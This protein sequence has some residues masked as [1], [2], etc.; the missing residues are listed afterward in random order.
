MTQQFVANDKIMQSKEFQKVSNFLS[1]KPFKGFSKEHLFIKR[2]IKKAWGQD[3]AALSNMAEAVENLWRRNLIDQQNAASQIQTITRMAMHKTVRPYKTPLEQTDN[4]GHYGYF[5]EHLNLILNCHQ[6]INGDGH[7]PLNERITLHLKTETIK[8]KNLHAR[9]LP[10]VRMRWSADQALIINS[11]RGFDRNN[12]TTHHNDLADAWISKM[13]RDYCHSTGLFQTEVMNCK[14][15]SKEPRGC[16][17]AY[18]IYYMHNFAPEVAESQWNLFKKHMK[19]TKLGLSG[20]REYLPEYQGRWTPDSGP[21]VAGLGVAASGL[22]LKTAAK[23]NDR[24]TYESLARVANPLLSICHA[25][26]RIPL[27][28]IVG[29]LGSDLLASSIRLAAMSITNE[30]DESCML[31]PPMPPYSSELRPYRSS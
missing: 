21:I 4:L 25:T 17:L 30:T 28:N 11:I 12:G 24:S 5:L 8:Q 15:Y 22:A 14:S 3:I 7:L 29:K 20:F 19:V 27:L 26:D 2:F 31:G 9:L 6:T 10:H 13:Q 18:L 23:L 16:A 1:Y